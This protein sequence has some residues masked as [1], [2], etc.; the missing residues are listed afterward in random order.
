MLIAILLI[1]NPTAALSQPDSLFLV[2]KRSES[3]TRTVYG[4]IWG[5]LTTIFACTWLAIHPNIPSP[6]DSQL[7]ILSR[8]VMIMG[9]AILVPEYTTV[10]AFRQWRTTK[11]VSE[12]MSHRPEWTVSHSFFVIMGG[13]ML[14]DGENRPVRPLLVE[15]VTE[16]NNM[17]AISLPILS[18]REIQDRSKGDGLSKTFILL[19]T[20]WFLIQVSARVVS[21]L[22]MTELELVTVAFATLNILAYIFWYNKP[23]NVDCPV[24]TPIVG[25]LARK[26]IYNIQ[27]PDR[28]LDGIQTTSDSTLDIHTTN[29]D[30]PLQW[31]HPGSLYSG[32]PGLSPPP[33]TYDP[34][35]P[36]SSPALS[37]RETQTADDNGH[38]A[39]AEANQIAP[40]YSRCQN[41]RL[42]LKLYVS[43]S[44]ARLQRNVA[45]QVFRPGGSRYRPNDV[46]KSQ[47]RLEVFQLEDRSRDDLRVPTFYC[48]SSPARFSSR[49]G[50]LQ[51]YL[52]IFFGAIHCCAWNF[53]FPGTAPLWLWR[54]SAIVLTTTPAYFM[55]V[56]ESVLEALSRLAR[57]L[58]FQLQEY[59]L[60]GDCITRVLRAACYYSGL[61]WMF[62]K[63]IIK[64]PIITRI[65]HCLIFA[66]YFMARVTL[67]VLP[68]VLLSDPSPRVLT[69][70]EW[71]KYLPHVKPFVSME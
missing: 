2:E 34:A 10:W 35:S 1:L 26:P 19:Q 12:K 56:M 22:A 18:E 71:T 60:K 23:L 58:S 50:N 48:G 40:S 32:A 64:R 46:D 31:D 4:I 15:D 69:E 36:L 42:A 63:L 53:H 52:G 21:G 13:F 68:F 67:I 29:G 41:L 5:C 57:H 37:L 45:S 30:S 8:K 25:Q 47:L 43:K 3:S 39:D 54:V 49:S 62:Q 44:I 6:N 70:V 66:L 16:R 9:L 14:V 28:A 17:G 20:T 65:L 27:L 55:I 7:R 11:R 33:P 51:L 59:E 61:S 24:S 38:L